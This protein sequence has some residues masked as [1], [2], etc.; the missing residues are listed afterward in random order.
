MR[1]AVLE[2]VQKIVYR[3][4]YPKP[5]IGPNDVLV[6]VHYCGI[7][8]SDV[9]NFKYKLY[10]VP[11][12]LGHEISG[13]VSEV[14]TNITDV[15]V[16][17]KVV[18]MNV[19]LD[20]YKET[21]EGMGIFDN[22]GF[23]E[24]V[25]VK[26]RN[27]FHTPENISI[28]GATMIESF[29]NITRAIRISRM[30]ENEKVLI[31][32]GGN[33]GLTFLTTVLS[34]KNPEY[35]IVVEPHQFL[36]EKAIEFGANEAIIPNKIKIKKLLKTFGAPTY[37]FDSVGSEETILMAIDLIG[38]GGTILVEGMQRIKISIRILSIITKE[39][40]LK[41]CLGHDKEDILAAIDLF[42]KNKIDPHKLISELVNLEDLQ[43]TFEKLIEPGERRFIKLLVKV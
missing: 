37:I 36:R 43:K 5:V 7:C 2:D 25:R 13:V 15:R 18:A 23:A 1:A 38:R 35:I 32:G 16:D 26:R 31:I 29:A 28:K 20:L 14:G 17:D 10:Q 41:G 33:I 3:E 21:F 9:P 4:D 39:I 8:G 30:S 11:L 40:T 24:Y 19:L 22:G 12:I 27:L 34:E 6:K 42:A